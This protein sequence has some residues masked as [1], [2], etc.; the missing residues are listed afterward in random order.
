V[1]ELSV[2][3]GR[4]DAG[5]RHVMDVMCDTPRKFEPRG[6]TTREFHQ[7]RSEH[8]VSLLIVGH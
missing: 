4:P 8:L 1:D 3:A 5:A 2:G 6:L 7:C